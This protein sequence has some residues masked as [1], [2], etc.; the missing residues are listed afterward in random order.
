M[1]AWKFPQNHTSSILQSLTMSNRTLTP[2]GARSLKLPKPAAITQT[3]LT[4]SLG[5]P[6]ANIAFWECSDKPQR[7]DL[8]PAFA[9]ALG[10]EIHDLIVDAR[11]S[12]K[13]KRAGPVGE[14]Q[15]T[16]EGVKQLP[17]S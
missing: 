15:K 17:R 10:V 4:E 2:Q 9:K 11:S 3:E 13:T 16:F 6:H 8:L 7:S 1:T 14:I 5:V 12:R